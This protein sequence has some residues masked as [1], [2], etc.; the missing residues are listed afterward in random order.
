MKPKPL[1]IKTLRVDPPLVLAPMSGL[2]H[3]VLRQLVAEYGGCGL[4]YSEMLSARALP[5]ESPE[6]ST[7]L[8]RSA[9]ER[10]IIYQLLVSSGEELPGAIEKVDAC[11]ADGLDLNMGCT[12]ALITKRGGGIA[13]M[14]DLK[15]AQAIVTV[16]RQ[17][18]QLPLTAKIR[19]GW[20]LN[21]HA[22][23]DFCLMLQESGV[24]AI[25]VHPR[26]KQ[27]RLKRPARW[28]Y[29]GRIKGLLD[30]PVIGN[31]DV[32]SPEAALR[33]FNQTGCDAV[34]IGRAAVRRPWLFSQI[35]GWLSPS[36]H[37]ESPP[38]PPEAYNRF[39]SLLNASIDPECALPLLKRFTFYF[40]QNYAFGH[41]L[42]RLVHN[43]KSTTEAL[44]HANDFFQ[45]QPAKPG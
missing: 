3:T 27:D 30:I 39:V 21:W 34:M 44:A 6:S 31:G 15:R 18:T 17:A 12:T 13:L 24:D 22:L 9:H 11:G 41:T 14:K 23:R 1:Y 35:T 43:A 16:S 10:P 25:S 38:E 5:L 29:I 8:R 42:W 2:S 36:H 26:L 4:F 33:M 20:T 19:L 45:T 37:N 32:D 40:A 28:E 7:W